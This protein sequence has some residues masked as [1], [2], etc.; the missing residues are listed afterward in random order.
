[1]KIGYVIAWA[2]FPAAIPVT[3]GRLLRR[4]KPAARNDIIFFCLFSSFLLFSCAPAAQPLAQTEIIPVYSTSAA[5]PW[6]SELFGCANDLSV[7]LKVT[8][9]SPEIYLRL[10]EPETLLSPAYQIA[11]EEILIVTNRESPVQNLSLEETQVLFA[12][13]GDAS[14]QVWGYASEAD[15]QIVFDQL[16]MK[17]R[18]VTSFA[19][20]AANPQELS[21]VLNSESNSIGILPKH[22]VAGSVREVYSAGI[23]PVLA[24]TKQEPQ[25]LVNLLIS[26][27]QK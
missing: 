26:C 12:G 13:Q 11:E 7:T 16:V 14:V 3:L 9:D 2:F 27:L 21:D 22:W 19:R 20:M 15:V 5:Q 1:M 10:G 6:M 8:A 17:G 24:I 23:V 25:R 4:Q 18:S